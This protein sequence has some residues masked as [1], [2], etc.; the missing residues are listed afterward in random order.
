MRGDMNPL[1]ELTDT[2]DDGSPRMDPRIAPLASVAGA[3]VSA[4]AHWG[5]VIPRFGTRNVGLSGTDF[6]RCAG[7]RV[8]IASLTLGLLAASTRQMQP[9]IEA[10][11]LCHKVEPVDTL[12]HQSSQI[13]A[14]SLADADWRSALGRLAGRVNH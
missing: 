10:L 2:K 7:S 9:S 8:D 5:A 4:H 3:V 11:N 6:D 1:R 12:V 13:G 14:S